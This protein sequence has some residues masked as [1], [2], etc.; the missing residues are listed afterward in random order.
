LK[1]LS[2]LFNIEKI[3]YIKCKQWSNATP[4]QQMILAFNYLTKTHNEYV[5]S[6]KNEIYEVNNDLDTYIE[7][8]KTPLNILLFD[9]TISTGKTIYNVKKYLQ[10]KTHKLKNVNIKTAC[11]ITNCEN[12]ADYF[13]DISTINIMWEWGVEL[14]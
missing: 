2:G 3:S 1:Y 7:N 11:I 9:D 6:S 12:N 10:T 14:D 8:T 4:E 13:V 5:N